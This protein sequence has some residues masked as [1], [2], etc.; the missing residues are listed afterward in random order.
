MDENTVDKEV[1][2]EWVPLC[3]R[4]HLP[5]IHIL[6]I[7]L[8]TL[9]PTVIFN[10]LYTI[11]TPLVVKLKIP[12]IGRTMI[13]F[14]GG[15]IGFTIN[16]MAGVISDSVMFKYGRRRIFMVCGGIGVVIFLL[17]MMYCVEIGEYLS[18]ENT[19]NAQRA[20]MI[21]SLELAMIAGNCVTTPARSLCSDV[22]PKKQQILVSSCVTVYSGLGGIFSNIVGGL[23]LYKYT[24]LSQESFILIVGIILFFISILITIIVTREEPLTEKPESAN[25]FK[26]MFLAF[27]NM[28]PP[29]LRAGLCF[30]FAQIA[31]YQIGV[32]QTDF[33]GRTIEGGDNAIDAPQEE[34]DKYQKGVSWAMMCNVMNYGV[35]FIYS[36]VHTYVCNFFGMKVVFIFLLFVLAVMYLLYFFVK[37]KIAFLF[38]NLPVG[39]ATVAYL[40]IPQAVVSLT[41][42]SETLGSYLGSLQIFGN[43]GCQISNFL[44]GMGG[45]EIWPNKPEV[46]IGVS[47]VFAFIDAIVGF[48][49]IIPESKKE[50][51]VKSEKEN[52]SSIE[53]DMTDSVMV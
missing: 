27:K 25:P 20:V 49:M 16:P 17:I 14:S 44:I 43:V 33:M 15:V 13:L 51:M 19:L 11:F 41:V 8:G 18:K 34:I 30:F 52:S 7:T 31:C 32:Q 4:D 47:S 24:S 29:V 1:N 23:Q 42:S 5:L 46:L 37:S 40:A 35:Q 50:D 10:I 28:P 21:V 39:L 45:S 12:Q 22:T 48:F 38:I 6:G 2:G 36:F 26:Q 53:L 9:A 3:K